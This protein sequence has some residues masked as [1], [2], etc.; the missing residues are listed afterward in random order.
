MIETMN[1]M[2]RISR[3]LL[4]KLGRDP[5]PKEL[6][7][8]MEMPEEKIRKIQKISLDPVSL[9]TPIGEEDNS[10]LGDFIAND[11]EMAPPDTVIHRT[12]SDEIDELLKNL[13]DREAKVLKMRFGLQGE[14]EHTWK[15]LANTSR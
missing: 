13:T 1:R 12:L 14:K 9:E 11:D 6:A 10:H 4:Q 2:N 3:K 15:R 7:E 5:N 8:E